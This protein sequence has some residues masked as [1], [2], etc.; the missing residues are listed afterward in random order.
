MA[1]VFLEPQ[2]IACAMSEGLKKR[3]YAN[4]QRVRTL[5]RRY[6]K[7]PRV[8]EKYR[9]QSMTLTR[10]P[11][12][13]QGHKVAFIFHSYIFCSI[14]LCH[15]LLTFSIHFPDY[16]NVFSSLTSHF[17][18]HANESSGFA[19][20]WLCAHSQR[21]ITHTPWDSPGIN[22]GDSPGDQPVLLRKLSLRQ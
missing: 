21:V 14:F 7:F 2:N 8:L 4:I 19:H 16:H 12:M 9:V 11:A 15:C 10:W 18:L 1:E 5:S 6:R 22:Q 13:E 3:V 17:F 20:K